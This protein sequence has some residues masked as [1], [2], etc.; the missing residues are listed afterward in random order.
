MMDKRKFKEGKK[1]ISVLLVPHFKGKV[2]AFKITSF[3]PKLYACAAMLLVF[4]VCAGVF[5]AHTLKENK[6]LKD[7][8]SQLYNTNIEQ[9]KLL[10]EKADEIAQLKSRDRNL[11]TK[12]RDFTEKYREMTETYISSRLNSSLASRSGDRGEQSFV[13][14][15]K[16]LKS[17]LESLREISDSEAVDLSGLAETEKKLKEYLDTIPTL[18]P[19]AGRV[20]DTFGYRQ[21]PFTRKKT[22]HEGLDISAPYGADIKAAASGKVV[23][24]GRQSGYGYM[25]II[26]HGRGISTAYGHASR[27]LVKEGQK[28]KK[29]DVIAKVGSTGRSTGPHL[30]FEVRLNDTPVDPSKYLD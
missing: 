19:A 9:R 27:L 7:T 25:V 2:K 4:F 10:S 24:S 8:V 18:W 12:I 13:K 6:E 22:F 20:S 26:D 5:I 30:H 17:I 28:V 16:E 23:F 15:I 3:Y 14:D 29:G 11:D 1:C 21:D